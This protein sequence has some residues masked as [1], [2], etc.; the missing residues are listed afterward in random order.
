MS[1]LDFL[2]IVGLESYGFFELS[3]VLLNRTVGEVVG[4]IW[5]VECLVLPRLLSQTV[6]VIEPLFSVPRL[7]IAVSQLSPAFFYHLSCL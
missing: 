7:T 5:V 6:V 2:I 4:S 1:K 3:Q